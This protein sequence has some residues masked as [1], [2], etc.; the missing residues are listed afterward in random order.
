MRAMKKNQS[1]ALNS[2]SHS[3]TALAAALLTLS[4][5]TIQAADYYWDTNGNTAGFGTASG[6]WLNPTPGGTT[7]WSTDS[8]GASAIGS[9]TTSTG[10][11]MY[12]GAD[13]VGLAAGTV[14]IGAAVVNVGGLRFGKASGD[15]TLTG[16]DIAMAGGDTLIRASSSAGSVTNTHT[17]NNDLNKTEGTLVISLSEMVVS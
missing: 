1:S 10:D 16:G 11:I 9:V 3:K 14:D 4:S 5:A 15:I 6:T 13:T 12:F 7:G 8:T 17:I 2:L